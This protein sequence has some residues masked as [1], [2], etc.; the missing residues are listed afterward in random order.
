[1]LAFFLNYPQVIPRLNRIIPNQRSIHPQESGM[2]STY[3]HKL[4]T[5]LWMDFTVFIARAMR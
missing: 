3:I 2:S 4:S 1:M 5:G